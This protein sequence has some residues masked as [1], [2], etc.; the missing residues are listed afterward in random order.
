MNRKHLLILTLL[1][2]SLALVAGCSNPANA[3]SNAP[4][5]IPEATD[6]QA[7]A[8]G[9]PQPTEVTIPEDL[10]SWP[11]APHMFIDP[12]KI[13]VATFVTEKGDIVVELDAKNAP[14]TTNNFIFLANEGF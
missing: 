10:M 7:Q 13:Y 1:I 12:E 5:P 2:L 14:M 4:T 9:T 3:Q 8:Q 11:M 6:A